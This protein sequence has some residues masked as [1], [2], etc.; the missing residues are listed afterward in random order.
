MRL[1]PVHGEVGGRA[2]RRLLAPLGVAL[3]L[4]LTGLAFA[5]PASAHATLVASSPQ[6]GARVDTEPAAVQLRFDEVIGLIPGAEQ[7]ISTTGLRADTGTA[8]ITGGGTTIVLPL[9]PNL[10]HGTYSATWR[11][12]S[13]DTHIVSGSITFGLG[14]QPSAG[15]AGPPDHTR[16]LAVA[17]DVAQGLVYAGA[18]LLV[19]LRA[20]TVLLW[21]WA[22]HTRRLAVTVRVGW[23]ALLAGTV[24]QFLLQGPRA[25][26]GSWSAFAHLDG[27]GQTLDSTYGNQLLARGALL[28]VITPL[29]SPDR[30]SRKGHADAGQPAAEHTD[31][32]RRSN[33]SRTPSWTSLR[34]AV[35]AAAGL[36]VLISIAVTGHQAVGPDVPLALPAAVLHLAGAVIWLGGL[37]ALAAIVLPSARHGSVD[38]GHIRLRQWSA[39]AYSCVVVLIVTGEYQASRQIS[40]VQALW[41]TRYGAILLI[42]TCLVAIM[43]AAAYLAQRHLRPAHTS[44]ESATV[45]SDPAQ[46]TPAVVAT[47]T[48]TTGVA[49]TPAARLLARHV[50]RSVL[51]EATAAVLVLAATTVLV[52]QAPARET[53]GPAV[54][55][56]APLGPD[57]VSI[58]VDT[59]RRGPQTLTIRVLDA[60]GTP[61][62][63]KTLTASLSSATIATLSLTLAR[64][65]GD[66]TEWVSRSAVA[67]L[68]GAWTLQLNVGLNATTAY[69]TSTTYQVW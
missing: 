40:P 1:A 64:A 54:T 8:S 17:D 59:T 47:T 23:A 12:V 58:H 38:L 56:D 45:V 61:V 21:A 27:F 51:V 67:P 48:R 36:A 29:L 13:A 37:V 55:L 35:A 44:C 22:A 34:L 24:L 66:R 15:V 63:V 16:A 5:G 19:G 31:Q 25:A 52:S 46:S 26:N 3:G 30:L 43:L 68:P 18:V 20:V 4:L 50:G 32:V 49:T 41:S 11:V 14:I 28:V 62:A 42:K 2:G 60:A 69:T 57:R 39:L 53:Y 9:K 7:V 65:T 6:D 33:S 10:P